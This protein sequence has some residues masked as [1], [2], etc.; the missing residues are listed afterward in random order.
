MDND[1]EIIERMTAYQGYFRIDRYRLRHR[2]FAG[3]AS[4][5]IVRE[6]L[7]RGQSVAVLP[8][9]PAR[10]EVVLIEQFRIGAHA[11]GRSPWL[12]EIVAGM[13]EPGEAAD[14]VARRETQEEAGLPLDRLELV[15][16]V[17]VSPGSTSETVSIFCGEADATLA[18]GVH[19]LDAE[20][21]DIRVLRLTADE[22]IARVQAR[23]IVYGPAVIAIQWLALNRDD[24]RRR[25]SGPLAGRQSGR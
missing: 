10:D 6:L 19:G 1:L 5:P 2:L 3:G 25:W 20:G 7:E 16:D 13:M 11:A 17:L 12:I 14:V 8:Y 4:K 23:E 18:N 15:A 21:E 22:A 9:D 24:L